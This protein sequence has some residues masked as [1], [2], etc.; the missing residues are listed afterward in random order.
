MRIIDAHHHFWEPSRPDLSWLIHGRPALNDAFG[1]DDLR[2]E[3]EAAGVGS[4]VLVQAANTADETD[5]VLRWAS[6]APFV[7]GAVAW[8]P[9]ERP[10]ETAAVLERCRRHPKFAGIRH[11]NTQEPDPDWLMRGDVL[12]SLELLAEHDVPLDVVVAVPR[13]LENVTRVAERL[14]GLRLVVDHLGRPPLPE[15]GWEPWADLLARAAEHPRVYAKVSVGL[16]V[17]DSHSRWSAE[18]LRPY[19]E[20]AIQCFGVGR[21]MAASNWPVCLLGASYR[22]VWENT[23][24]VLLDLPA[25]DRATIMGETA[26]AVYRPAGHRSEEAG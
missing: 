21:L 2:A 25:A 14:P 10:E 16:D 1:P 26:A 12:A 20:H 5:R 17:L 13:H 22:R 19:V 9:L 3:I 18:G 7:H 6:A 15:G 24:A 23:A 8:A 11:V 4:T